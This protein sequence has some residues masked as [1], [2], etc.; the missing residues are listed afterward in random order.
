[1]RHYRAR[2]VHEARESRILVV[3]SPG[4]RDA[5]DPRVTVASEWVPGTES[6]DMGGEGARKTI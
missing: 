2:N 5:R 6:D 4:S 1:M 3:L